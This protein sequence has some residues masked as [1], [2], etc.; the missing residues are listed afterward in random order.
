MPGRVLRSGVAWIVFL[1]LTTQQIHASP[2]SID[3]PSP[4]DR[5]LSEL[6][7]A[8][9][10]LEEGY[11]QAM[12]KAVLSSTDKRSGEK[13]TTEIH[14]ACDSGLS[15]SIDVSHDAKSKAFES[16]IRC[17]NDDYSFLLTRSLPDRPYVIQNV[18]E[19]SKRNIEFGRYYIQGYVA[20]PYIAF[21]RPVRNL[22]E[23]PEF[24]FKLV[25]VI[26]E[27]VDGFKPLQDVVRHPPGL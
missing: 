16:I 20:A 2:A 25:D 21:G 12:G 8:L 22:M 5:L 26:E 1:Q 10:R 14:F 23:R 11:S 18:V 3:D 13:S 27:S 4:R 15:R 9:K 6:P 7:A 17:S 24:G 19:G